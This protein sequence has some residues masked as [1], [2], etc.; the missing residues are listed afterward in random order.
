MNIY[1][2]KKLFKKVIKVK[3]LK[4][5][6]LLDPNTINRRNHMNRMNAG[7][8]SKKNVKISTQGKRTIGRPKKR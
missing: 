8:F 5:L 1:R 7:R 4:Y 3:G 2:G 6:E